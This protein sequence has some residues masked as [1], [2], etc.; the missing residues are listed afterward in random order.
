[1]VNIDDLL[2]TINQWGPA[3]PTTTADFNNDGLV[4][5][6]DILTVIEEWD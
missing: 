4:N 3:I 6:A 1:V 2:R 5:V